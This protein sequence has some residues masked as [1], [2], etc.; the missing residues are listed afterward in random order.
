MIQFRILSGK[1]AGENVFAR[2]FPFRI[3][4][5]SEND[6]VVDDVGVWDSHL[7]LE[8]KKPDG[9]ILKTAAEAFAAVNDEPQKE[10]RLRNGDII[11]FGS[12][13]IQFW[14]APPRQGGLHIREYIAWLLIAAVTAVQFFLIYRLL[15]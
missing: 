1:M 8:F 12:A 13:K 15:Q 7:S 11:S 14:L 2:R 3:G 6:L 9:F 5:A 10:V 4:R